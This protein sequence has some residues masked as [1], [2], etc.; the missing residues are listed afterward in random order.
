MKNFSTILVPPTVEYTLV[1]ANSFYGGFN[2]T[3]GQ[4]FKGILFQEL[5]IHGALSPLVVV[6]SLKFLPPFNRTVD[7]RN[8]RHSIN[9]NHPNA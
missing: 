8:T 7:R 4:Y 2:D 3:S 1:M 6:E 5:Y 9:L